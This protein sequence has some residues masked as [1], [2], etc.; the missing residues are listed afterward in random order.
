MKKRLS[1]MIV[2]FLLAFF[3][4]AEIKPARLQCEYE[5]NPLGIDVIKPRLSWIVQSNERGQRQMA[6]Q[7]LVA[8]NE[9]EL[10]NSHGDIW[11]T[12]K[13]ESSQTIQISHNGEPLKSRALLLEGQGLGQKWQV[14][15]ME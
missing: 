10:R 12:A 5:L 9:R 14:F 3:T 15:G 11:D 4:R 7:I 6:H 2:L 13:V 8:S 1:A